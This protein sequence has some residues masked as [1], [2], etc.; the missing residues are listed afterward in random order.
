MTDP[1]PLASQRI[2]IMATDGF[3]QSELE[4]PLERLQDAGADVDIAS[5]ET[6]D[7]TGWD[8]GDWGDEIEVD[9]KISDVKIDD[10]GALV[11]PGGQMNPDLLR[12]DADA[13]AL[14][15]EFAAAG[16]PVAAICHAPWLLIEAGLVKGKRMTSYKSIRTDMVNAG[17]DFVDEAVVVDGHIITS[18]CPDDLPA[19]CDAIVDALAA[20][21]VAA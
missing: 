9:L 21:K 17:A 2:L 11:L 16:K 14:I 12:V 20:A 15:R 3:E 19:F 7:I 5:L 1:E 8:D 6:G 18:R 13:I 4:V 10:Y